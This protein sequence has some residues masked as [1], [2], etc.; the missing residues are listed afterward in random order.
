MHQE[1][2]NSVPSDSEADCIHSFICGENVFI[3]WIDSIT[4]LDFFCEISVLL[5]SGGPAMKAVWYA[6]TTNLNP[7]LFYLIQMR[8]LIISFST[9]GCRIF[10]MLEG[11]NATFISHILL[12]LTAQAGL[13]QVK[14]ITWDNPLG[15]TNFFLFLRFS[16]F[17]DTYD[18]AFT[19]ARL[20]FLIQDST[21][22]QI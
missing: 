7:S 14:R 12:Y 10:N 11:A 21:F 13:L 1:I 19:L 4:S 3:V 6:A 20:N 5:I 2:N 17:S 8:N 15:L 9:A 18:A 22:F 16:L